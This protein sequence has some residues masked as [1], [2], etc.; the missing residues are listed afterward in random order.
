MVNLRMDTA[1]SAV[2]RLTSSRTH[3]T[4]ASRGGRTE[5]I[6]EVR[7]VADMLYAPRAVHSWNKN[8]ATRYSSREPF[9][10]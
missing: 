1:L 6:E 9:T 8:S 2:Y 10:A 4:L 3:R 7:C 5:V